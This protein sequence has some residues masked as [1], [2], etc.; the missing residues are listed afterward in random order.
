[1]V[2]LQATVWAIF[3]GMYVLSWAMGLASE[4]Y[5]ILNFGSTMAFVWLIAKI[6]QK[7]RRNREWRDYYG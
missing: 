5:L 1:M 4:Q 2:A 6:R 3:V 7:L